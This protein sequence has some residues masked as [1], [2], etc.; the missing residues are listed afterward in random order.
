MSPW[1]SLWRAWTGSLRNRLMVSVLTVHAVLMTVF[2]LDL[3]DKEREFNR[4]DSRLGAEA[5]VHTFATNATSWVLANDLVGLMETVQSLNRFPELR[6]AMVLSPEGQVLA[7]SDPQQR[8]QFVRDAVSLRLLGAG[9][10]DVPLV[11]NDDLI[12]LAAPVI[13][14]GRLVG[15]ARVGIG[16]Q[17]ASANLTDIARTGLLA[18]LA[19]MVI[20]TLAAYL[21]AKGTTRGLASLAKLAD[22]VRSGRRDVRARSTGEDEVG[23]LGRDLDAMLDA[24]TQSEEQVT[25]LL[26]STAEGIFGLSPD[27]TVTFANRA[28]LRMLGYDRAAQVL[29][30]RACEVVSPNRPGRRDG[31]GECEIERAAREGRMA[32]SAEQV[33]L[34]EGTGSFPVE[35]W[36]YPIQ[37][38]G[39]CVGAVVTFVDITERQQLLDQI[40]GANEVLELRVKERTQQ[41]ETANRQMVAVNKELEMFSYSASHDLRAPLRSIDGFS[42]ILLAD[43][44]DRLDERGRDYLGR[45]RAASQRMAELIDDLLMLSRVTRASLELEPVDLSKIAAEVME[46]QRATEPGREA[47]VLIASGLT[48]HGDAKLLRAVLENLLGNSWNYSSR[49]PRCRIEFGQERAQGR[50]A[51]FVRDNGAGF[52]MAYSNKLFVPFQRLHSAKEFPGNGVG[53]ASVARIIRRHGGDVW[54]QGAV[55]QGATFWFTLG[56]SAG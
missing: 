45:V 12:D 48:A 37:R 19:A 11:V 39:Q 18:S 3:L 51:F 55:G 47:E 4:K 2:V 1:R 15:W 26:N 42:E 6:Y 23:R 50:N 7:S 36:S 49:V 43:Y 17:Q 21:I 32:H 8:G 31:S 54:A 28:C 52:D 5:L 20:G 25:L 44:Q 46:A 24:L 41:L 40:R 16:Q 35:F 10:E 14:G 56:D 30:R 9:P 53:L 34:R 33:F 27:G 22:E 13:S 38:A 29:G